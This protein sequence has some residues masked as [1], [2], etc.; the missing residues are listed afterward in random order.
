MDAVCYFPNNKGSAILLLDNALRSFNI[1]LRELYKSAVHVL[2]NNAHRV[3]ILCIT[4]DYK[5]TVY[6][7]S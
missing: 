6:T 3:H 5:Y 7:D 4:Q 2:R 1:S